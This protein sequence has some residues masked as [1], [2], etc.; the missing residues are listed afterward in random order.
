MSDVL[1]AFKKKTF[2][3]SAAAAEDDGNGATPGDEA[4]PMATDKKAASVVSVKKTAK[5]LLSFEDE[6]ED[7]AFQASECDVMC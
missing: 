3:R 4:V 5:S 7:G 1:V 2:R 6:D